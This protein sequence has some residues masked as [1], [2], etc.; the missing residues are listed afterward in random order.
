M[1]RPLHAVLAATTSAVLLAS[2][3]GDEQAANETAAIDAGF[4]HIHG[5]G[6]NPADGNLYVASHFGIF[7]VE[8]SKAERIANRWQDTMGFAVI[9]PDHFLGSGHPDIRE[10]DQPTSLGLIES[11]DAAKT[12]TAVSMTGEADLHAIEPIGNRIY[13]YDSH[14]ASLIVTDDRTTWDTIA[15]QSLY[16]L[17]ADPSDPKTVYAT[18]ERGALVRSSDMGALVPVE[19]APTLTM[20]DWQPDGPLVGITP[21]GSVMTSIGGPSQW[22]KVGD[23]PGAAVA[24]EVDEDRWFAATEG[25]VFEC[26]DRG[27][28]WT[29]VVTGSAD[30]SLRFPPDRRGIDNEDRDAREAEEVRPGVP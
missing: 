18:T 26:S 8:G 4:G 3:T 2:C 12:W 17:A 10:R 28:S 19:G 11:T 6:I 1:K 20:I 9:G 13:A 21:D 22:S 30:N 23:L 16:D 25:G 29:P 14:T 24:L 5:L 7:R 27:R 15:T